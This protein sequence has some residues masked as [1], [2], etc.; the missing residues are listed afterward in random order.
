MRHLYYGKNKKQLP[1]LPSVKASIVEQLQEPLIRVLFGLGLL[2]CFTGLADS[3]LW[4]WT[5]GVS[6]LLAVFVLVLVGALTDY[7]KD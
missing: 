6:I 4:G 7:S 1:Q 2:A 5:K 3:V